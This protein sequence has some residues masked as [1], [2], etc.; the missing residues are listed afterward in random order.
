MTDFVSGFKYTVLRDGEW[1]QV[2]S[3]R[4]TVGDIIQVKKDEMIPAD[5]LLLSTSHDK[6]QCFIDNVNLFGFH[7]IN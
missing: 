5:L 7:I 1:K 6:G 3:G 4:L 2:P